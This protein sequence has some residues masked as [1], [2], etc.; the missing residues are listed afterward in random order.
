MPS[1]Q[2]LN[3]VCQTSSWLVL[4]HG[5]YTEM[6]VLVEGSARKKAARLAILSENI[7]KCRETA[8]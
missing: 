6:Y 3:P 1:P 5:F 7:V 2:K 4:S 8:A